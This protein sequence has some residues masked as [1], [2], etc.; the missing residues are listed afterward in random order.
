VSEPTS[1]LQDPNLAHPPDSVGDQALA[2][3]LQEARTGAREI[4]GNNLGP[5]V[6]KYLNA[7]HPHR[8]THVEEPWCAAFLC[9]CWMHAARDASASLS[10]GYTRS[11]NA[12]FNRLAQC[13]QAVRVSRGEVVSERA[14][15]VRLAPQPG[16]ACFWDFSGNGVPDHV[17][18]VVRLEGEGPEAVLHTIGGNEGSERSGAPVEVKRRGRLCD[19]PA[20][21]G[22]G[23]PTP[24]R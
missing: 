3:A 22:F 4:G 11:T 1:E 14:A 10:V 9:W 12:L 23:W 6:E 21:Y 24:R 16:D 7:E 17:N 13:D 8:V 20:L 18:M 15:P 19:L 2:Y 5:W